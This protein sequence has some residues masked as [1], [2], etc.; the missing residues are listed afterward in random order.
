MAEPFEPD[1]DA[2]DFMACLGA[3]MEHCPSPKAK[4]VASGLLQA[5]QTEIALGQT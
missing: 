4:G 5:R 1:N 2:L 3:V